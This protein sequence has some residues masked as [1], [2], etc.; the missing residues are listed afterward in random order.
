MKSR[1]LKD[2]TTLM[3]LRLI[4][5]LKLQML[6][7]FTMGNTTLD[8]DGFASHDVT[9][10]NMELLQ[11]ARGV[12]T[13]TMGNTGPRK[14]TMRSAAGDLMIVFAKNKMP[15][16]QELRLKKAR[17]NRKLIG[18]IRLKLLALPLLLEPL[19]RNI[20]SEE[21]LMHLVLIMMASRM[22]PLQSRSQG[23]VVLRSKLHRDL[24]HVLRHVL[25]HAL[26]RILYLRVQRQEPGIEQILTD[27]EQN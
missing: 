8:S 4:L 1:V 24:P 25:L 12:Q 6:A 22:N 19:P 13:W 20:F 17:E 26:P 15:N 23:G 10:T 27:F 11:D 7:K 9:L 16:G 2:R 3:F 14:H 18:K 21:T 5:K